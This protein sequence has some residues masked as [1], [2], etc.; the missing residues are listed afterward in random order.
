M[1]PLVWDGLAWSLL[2]AVRLMLLCWLPAELTAGEAEAWDRARSGDNHGFSPLAFWITVAGSGE[3]AMRLPSLLWAS[4]GLIPVYALTRQMYDVTAARLAVLLLA[5]LPG[6]TFA[7]MLIS[8]TAAGCCAWATALHCLWQLF[9]S[10]SRDWKWVV[11]AITATGMGIVAQP[12]LGAI[13]PLF[14]LF[15]ISSSVGGRRWRDGRLWTWGI[16]SLLLRLADMYWSASTRANSGRVDA[17]SLSDPVELIQRCI[18]WLASQFVAVSPVTLVLLCVVSVSLLKRFR[19]VCPRERF[20]LIFSVGPLGIEVLRSLIWP[21]ASVN[22]LAATPAGVIGL[23]GWAGGWV[24]AGIAA[25]RWR[26]WTLPGAA[27]GGLLTVSLAAGIMTLPAAVV[28]GG[29]LELSARPRG[30]REAA[31]II[32]E[33]RKSLPHAERVPVFVVTEQ[34]AACRLAFYSPGQ[35]DLQGWSAGEISSENSEWGAVLVTRS[36]GDIPPALSAAFGELQ[37]L[38]AIRVPEGHG[39]WI[40]L[41]V[42]RAR[43]APQDRREGL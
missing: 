16:S 32:D 8:A 13:L 4:L 6:Q 17:S 5:S 11:P 23:A 35:T 29:P 27:V 30:W 14:G 7:A 18:E 26:T 10:P 34:G 25:D 43:P 22:L 38:R 15:L 28:D 42:W 2:L 40:E 36:D 37:P 20:L 1:S 21:N 33:C 19:K 39:R 12:E 24:S 41:Q 9:V 3:I 31:A